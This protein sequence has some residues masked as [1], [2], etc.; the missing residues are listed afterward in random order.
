MH[1]S[2]ILL[3]VLA[4]FTAYGLV[5]FLLHQKRV[6]S[7]PIRVHVNGTRGKS[8]VTRL[9]GAGLRAGGIPTI[10]KVTGTYPRLILEDGSDVHIYRRG[11]ANIIEQISI[12]RY[13]AERKAQA[14]IVEC[15]ALEQQ[16]QRIT[17]RQMIHANV[18]VIT[19][20]RLDHIDIMGRTLPEI[21]KV[22]GETI[23]VRQHLFAAETVIPET[24]QTL[25]DKKHATMHRATEESV[26]QEE[27]KGFSYIEH[28]EN[29]ALAIDVCEHLGIQR[30]VALDGMY[31]AI[32]D[33][34]VLKRFT[35]D[36]YGK[37]ITF[38][39]AFAA[40][41][42]D[43][44]LL[45]WKRLRDEVGLDGTRIVLLNTRQDRM[46]R[47]RQLAE[48]AGRRLN[49]DM[50]YLML[51]GQCTEVVKGM[52]MGNGVDANRILAVGWTT[53]ES[54]FDKVLSVTDRASTIVAIGNMGG[55]GGKVADYFENRSIHVHD[56]AGNYA[57]VGPQPAIV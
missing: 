39:N 29:V 20:V 50:D 31:K 41:D 4:L 16:Y 47:A 2:Y 49:Q 23:P 56:R 46:D 48:L 5:E 11:D 53:P 30:R 34:G 21:A 9:I 24:L 57:G 26:T 17:E 18:G 12:V 15:M 28:R 40:N 22:L 44:T 14:L 33:A 37:Q 32:P 35:V 6:R 27:M 45:V 25:A 51:I 43:S 55:M 13:A 52:A 38:Y 36:T 19:N 54:V 7:I 1:T 8:S 10:T 42:P 3:L